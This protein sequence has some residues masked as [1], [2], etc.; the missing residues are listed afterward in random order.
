MRGFKTF[1]AIGQVF[2]DPPCKVSGGKCHSANRLG[3]KSWLFVGEADAM[4]RS[5]IV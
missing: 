4:E 2:D 5:A 3:K 1:R